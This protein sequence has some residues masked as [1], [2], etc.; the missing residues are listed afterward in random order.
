MSVLTI[1]GQECSR[2]AED[3]GYCIVPAEHAH[4]ERFVGVTA[5]GRWA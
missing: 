3:G 4:L 2:C 1:G 5:I